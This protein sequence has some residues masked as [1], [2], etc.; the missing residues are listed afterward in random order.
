MKFVSKWREHRI[1]MT[2]SYKQL[3][4]VSSVF[5]PGKAIQFVNNEYVTEDKEEI[6]F[7]RNHKEFGTIIHEAPDAK[8][9]QRKLVEMAE[10]IKE[11][12]IEAVPEGSTSEDALKCPVCGFVAKS[13]IGLASHMKTHA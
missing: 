11:A 5:V 3:V 7:L 2:P 12:E 13:K 9:A 6:Q 8:E 10:Q 4:G 1:V